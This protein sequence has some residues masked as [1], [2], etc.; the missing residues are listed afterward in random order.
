MGVSNGD[1]WEAEQIVS[2][3]PESA[4]TVRDGEGV[5]APRVSA[6]LANSWEESH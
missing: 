3:K 2:E 4:G 1:K 5:G 6:T